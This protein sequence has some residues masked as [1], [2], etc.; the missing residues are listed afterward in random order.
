MLGE[1]FSK[2]EHADIHFVAG[3]VNQ[4]CNNLISNYLKFALKFTF[5]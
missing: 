1:T 3:T 5:L 4:S 2:T